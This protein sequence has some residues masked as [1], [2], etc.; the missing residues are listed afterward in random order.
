M[1]LYLLSQRHCCALKSTPAPTPPIDFA[2]MLAEKAGI[3]AS[4]LA[5]TAQKIGCYASTCGAVSSQL[6]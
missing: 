2:S 6:G 3:V 5:V 1:R 4:L